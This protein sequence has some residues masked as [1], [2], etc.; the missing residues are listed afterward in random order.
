M[1]EKCLENAG[2]MSGNQAWKM[3]GKISR[4]RGFYAQAQAPRGPGSQKPCS[5]ALNKLKSVLIYHF[6]NSR[7][8]QCSVFI[9]QCVAIKKFLQHLF[10]NVLQK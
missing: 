1:L 6:L 2:N 4:S 7:G 3:S 9:F 10:K 5:P 8:R